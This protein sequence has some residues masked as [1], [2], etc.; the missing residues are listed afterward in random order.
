MEQLTN[1]HYS[2]TYS[3]EWRL[4]PLLRPNVEGNSSVNKHYRKKKIY[5]SK[6]PVPTVI[7]SN[8][9]DDT[10]IIAGEG[11]SEKFCASPDIVIL[12]E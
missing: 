5:I 12:R 8:G 1:L 4:L 9:Q 11:I 10:A 3:T 7:L 6:T 2:G